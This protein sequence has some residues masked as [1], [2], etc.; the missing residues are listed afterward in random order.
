MQCKPRWCSED[1]LLGLRV[2]YI[3]RAIFPSV[4][5]MYFPK[6]LLC[7][8]ASCW[9]N[10]AADLSYFHCSTT[11]PPP[12]QTFWKISESINWCGL[13]F[14]DF[15]FISIWH[16]LRNLQGSAALGS[17]AVAI[18]LE[19]PENFRKFI[20]LYK[21][22]IFCILAALLYFDERLHLMTK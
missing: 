8:R 22:H 5:C 16:I 18:L 2:S 9:S 7:Y 1:F 3:R 17:P 20:I 4:F 11:S 6:Q 12:T 21:F 13:C 10:V 19:A 14:C 15:Q